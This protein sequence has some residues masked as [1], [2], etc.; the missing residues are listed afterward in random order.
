MGE[1]GVL[2]GGGGNGLWE[3]SLWAHHLRRKHC[4]PQFGIR[5]K[6]IEKSGERMGLT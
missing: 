4:F 3:F 5:K 1:K 2:L 6:T